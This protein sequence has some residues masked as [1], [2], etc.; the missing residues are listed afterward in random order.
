M[1]AVVIAPGRA[2]LW[3]TRHA[4]HMAHSMADIGRVTLILPHGPQ[5][6]RMLPGEVGEPTILSNALNGWPI[7]SGGLGAALGLRRK[8]DVAVMVFWSGASPTLALISGLGSAIRGE[9]LVLDLETAPGAKPTRTGRLVERVLSRV[10]KTTIVGTPTRGSG[11]EQRKVAALCGADVELAQAVLD[12]F[13]GLSDTVAAEWH[14][15]LWVDDVEAVPVSSRH[16]ERVSVEAGVDSARAK[17]ISLVLA[18][19]D[20]IRRE[21]V[22]LAMAHGS[23]GVL[24]GHPAAARLTQGPDGVWLASR[25][26]SSILVAM[27]SATGARFD[28]PVSVLHLQDSSDR[29]LAAV[30]AWG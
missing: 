20:D 5:T 4:Q 16:A 1:S 10:A 24:I 28:N 30:A 6:E 26:P 13:S 27:E 11:V 22:E 23:A 7:W 17:G 2:P 15:T 25:T 8:R 12:A 19:H 14:L 29:L 21:F 9:R 3:V 18:P